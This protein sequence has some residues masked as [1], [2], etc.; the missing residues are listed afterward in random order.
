MSL[1]PQADGVD[2]GVKYSRGDAFIVLKTYGVGKIDKDVV[3]RSPC[4]FFRIGG[5]GAGKGLP[6]MP[7]LP[8]CQMAQLCSPEKADVMLAE[9][10]KTGDV[11]HRMAPREETEVYPVGA[12]I[13][14]QQV[15][16]LHI[17]V[18]TS[19]VVA[20][21]VDGRRNDLFGMSA[22]FFMLGNVFQCL[23]F[24]GREI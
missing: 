15:A 2:V 13:S 5:V 18:K 10:V 23:S 14:Y 7:H 11:E 24:S 16:R 4:E 1:S 19:R 3:L 22:I 17:S 6:K 21:A 20:K 8:A 9:K 12:V